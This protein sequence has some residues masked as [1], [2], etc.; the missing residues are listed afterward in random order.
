[1]QTVRAPFQYA[2]TLLAVLSS[3]ALA[4]ALGFTLISCI[5]HLLWNRLMGT[6]QSS[7][8]LWLETGVVVVLTG[9]FWY[10]I[11]AAAFRQHYETRDLETRIK[12]HLTPLVSSVPM[13]I[14]ELA[15]WYQ[16]ESEHPMAF[17]WGIRRRRIVL[18]K[19]LMDTLDDHAQ[20]AVM[21]HEAAH[22][23]MHDPLQQSIL[24]VLANAFGPLGLRALH[25]RYVVRREIL[26]DKAALA[27]CKGDDI[28]LLQALLAASRGQ[29]LSGTVASYVGMP[30]I[31][32]AR[33]EFL[34]TRKVPRVWDGDL[35]VR[36]FA[37]VMAIALTVGQG[38]LVW[39]H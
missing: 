8:L 23:R 19:G 22:V 5:R 10:R 31:M 1:M 28:P 17:T 36:M 16:L 21:H 37:S 3:A 26:A 29:V 2:Y 4:T 34:E 6:H 7:L 11:L 27:A 38:L 18:S 13:E 33:V 32:E 12:S 20:K 14:R 30:G 9:V 25:K 15:E 39:C 35:R 24:L